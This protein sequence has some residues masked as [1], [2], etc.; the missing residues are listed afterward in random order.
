M[1]TKTLLITFIVLFLVFI[2]VWIASPR[3]GEIVDIN[4]GVDVEFT[5]KNFEEPDELPEGFVR[6]LSI[7]DGAVYYVDKDNTRLYYEHV[8]NGKFIEYDINRPSYLVRTEFDRRIYQ[9]KI[10]DKLQEE[11]RAYAYGAWQVVSKD[12]DVILEVPENYILTNDVNVY[13]VNDAKNPTYKMLNKLGNQYVW[14]KIK[15]TTEWISI[16]VPENFAR[17]EIVNVYEG[18]LNNQKVYKKVIMFNDANKTVVIVAC[19][20]DGKFI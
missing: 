5:D 18:T 14:S 4:S 6:A 3:V 8:G 15:D 17:T 10:D 1:K 19:D 9:I 16:S 12:Y 2:A 13:F 11:Y 7:T 20:K